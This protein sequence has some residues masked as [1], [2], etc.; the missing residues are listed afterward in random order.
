M[1]DLL[2]LVQSF[3]TNEQKEFRHFLQR[4][5][6]RRERKDIQ[7][8]DVLSVNQIDSKS[9]IYQVLYQDIYDKNAYHSLRKRLIKQINDF[10]YLK[11]IDNNDSVS[12]S[13]NRDL[14][15]V[16][17]LFDHN[18]HKQAWKYLHKA[19]KLSIDA[20]LNSDL[21][22]IYNLMIEKYDQTLSTESL[23]SLVANRI[24]VGYLSK[25]EENLRIV[26]SLV[27]QE[28]EKVRLTGEDLNL[29][30][31]T[32][33]LLKQFD[34]QDS[35]FNRPRLLYNFILLMRTTV[36]A[37]KKY[38]SFEGFAINSYKKMLRSAYFEKHR[39]HHLNMLYIVAHTLYRNKKF[40]E[41]IFYLEQMHEILPQV[42]K[43]IFNQYYS[44]Y[45]LLLAASENFSGNLDVSIAIL[46]D[47]LSSDRVDKVD[48]LN[49]RLNLCVYYFEARD[50]QKALRS[51]FE[52]SHSDQWYEK[53]MGIEWRFKKNMIE[54]IFQY[55]IGNTEIAYNR[56]EA[57]QRTYRDLF[58][59]TK[60]SRVG[61][62]LRI[63]KKMI[64][65]PF[66]INSPD[67][68]EQIEQSFEWIDKEEED[69]QAMTYYAWLKSKVQKRGFYETMLELIR[70]I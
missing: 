6:S 61:V 18:L 65:E 24:K 53:I 35:V 36:L 30:E 34:L 20:E 44:K 47:L 50:Y 40:D 25:D 26:G 49:A 69:L 58:K 4:N 33:S 48:R 1:D 38:H 66:V 41:A 10:V 54:L 8:F 16:R 12:A 37:Q 31:V 27:R 9:E 70:N 19:E 45:F 57:M 62:F 17:H 43:G 29:D 56:I 21:R 14:T 11:R 59:T 32:D 23:E 2:D 15:L 55:E 5:N 52:F 68:A 46:E 39:S 63:I 13:I 67:F 64:Q 51:S 7:L 22:Q 28:L 60:Y 42:N 3:S